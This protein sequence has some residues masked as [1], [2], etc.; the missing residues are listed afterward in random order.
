MKKEI[1]ERLQ[2]ELIRLRGK[3][4]QYLGYPIAKGFKYSDLAPF[5]D[6]SINNLGDPY[7]TSSLSIDTKTIEVEVIEFFTNLLRAQ[8]DSVWGYVTNGGSEGNL[9]GLYLARDRF[10]KGIVYYSESTHYSVRKNLN[11]L[12]M[13]NIVIRS[14]ENGEL[15][16]DDLEK[17][18]NTHRDLPAIFFL[19]IGTTMKEAIDQLEKVK[20]I[21]KNLAIK[22]Y[23]IHADAALLG[24]IAPFLTPRPSFDFKDGIDSISISGHKFIGSPIPCGIVLTKKEYTDRISNSISYVSTKDTTITGSRNGLTPVILWYALKSLGMNGLRDRV[25]ACLELAEYTE[26]Q[27]KKIGYNAWRNKN[28]LT[29]VFNRPGQE[30]CDNFQLATEENIAHV[31]CIPGVSK[32]RIDKLINELKSSDIETTCNNMDGG[33]VVFLDTYWG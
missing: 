30:I 9:Y 12:N 23:Y 8:K 15:D 29:I 33:N 3:N 7:C 10:P 22:E 19:N 18:V 20:D 25:L 14:Q 21:I 6:L 13:Q 31:I 16:Y 24:V 32:E 28:A 11:L 1:K 4:D 26:E 5:L 27:L 17:C 2:L